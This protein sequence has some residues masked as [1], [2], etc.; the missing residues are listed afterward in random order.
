VVSL[1]ERRYE[2]KTRFLLTA[3]CITG[4]LVTSGAS[5]LGGDRVSRESAKPVRLADATLI[6]EVNA[7]DGDA[8]LQVFLDGDPWRSMTIT[9]PDGRKIVDVT[10]VGRL[11]GYGLTELFSESSEPPFDT[12]PLARF[13][14][15]WPE[16]RYSFSGVTIEG[17]KVTGAARL[18]HDIPGG[19]RIV[20]PTKNERVDRK[21]MVARWSA[22]P[23]QAGIEIAGYRAIVSREGPLRVFSADLRAWARRVTVPREFLERGV[24]YKI[25]VEA[26]EKSGNQTLTEVEFRVK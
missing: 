4:A 1:T 11:K 18:S 15:L 26:I 6:V 24:E 20:S 7:T 2:M 25:E 8:G 16:G 17:R 22:P 13:K 9:A 21:A 5:A 3:A 23:K 19:P 14:A 12:F 10:A